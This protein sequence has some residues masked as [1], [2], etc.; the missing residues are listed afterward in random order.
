MIIIDLLFYPKTEDGEDAIVHLIWRVF[1][2]TWN[3]AGRRRWLF[4]DVA[5][6]ADA[7]EWR[8]QFDQRPSPHH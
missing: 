2:L 7:N 1:P 5:N 8:I 3:Y 4:Y 6:S